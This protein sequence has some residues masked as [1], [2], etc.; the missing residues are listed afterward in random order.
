MSIAAM[1]APVRCSR[2]LRARPARVH[3]RPRPPSPGAARLD[4]VSADL[5]R[6]VVAVALAAGGAGAGQ[7]RAAAPAVEKHRPG[8]RVHPSRS[9]PQA[10]STDRRRHADRRR[11]GALDERSSPDLV[12]ADRLARA[13]GSPDARVAALRVGRMSFSRQWRALVLV[14]GRPGAWAGPAPVAEP[15]A[16]PV[17]RW[18]PPSMAACP[19]GP[20]RPIPPPVRPPPSPQLA[21]R[22]RRPRPAAPAAGPATSRR[23]ASA[24]THV[25]DLGPRRRGVPA[26]LRRRARE[27]RGAAT[28]SARSRSAGLRIWTSTVASG[29][30][31]G[32]VRRDAD[33]ARSTPSGAWPS[34]SR[35]V[36]RAA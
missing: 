18:P 31:P 33:R 27:R 32:R 16:A 8:G 10:G 20:S 1:V 35:S 26:P 6:H 24:V 19:T 29:V 17:P 7:A 15:P 22:R 3:W 36:V 30:D 12:L 9:A 28:A 5:R 34:Q 14:C 23:R 4:D 2:P 25:C 11:K 21:R 13:F